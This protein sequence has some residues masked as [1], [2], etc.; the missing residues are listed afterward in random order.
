M[1]AVEAPARRAA[2]AAE[3]RGLPGSWR[4]RVDSKEHRTALRIRLS[5]DVKIPIAFIAGHTSFAAPPVGNP[6]RL[7]SS[8]GAADYVRRLRAGTRCL[9]SEG[10]REVTFGKIIRTQPRW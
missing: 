9:C 4:S 2:V 7:R 8:V 3:H 1:K 6:C 5:E 10:R